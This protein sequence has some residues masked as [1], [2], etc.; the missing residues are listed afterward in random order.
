MIDQ[1]RMA[2][3]TGRTRHRHG[4]NGCLILQVEYR[5]SSI[6]V[7]RWRDARIEDMAFVVNA[8]RFYMVSQ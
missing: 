4:E 7:D 2:K 8:D 6:P 3:L 5:V 1:L